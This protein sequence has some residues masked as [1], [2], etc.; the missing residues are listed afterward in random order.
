MIVKL[1]AVSATLI[2]GTQT[3]NFGIML[4]LKPLNVLKN[5]SLSKIQTDYHNSTSIHM[6]HASS[7]VLHGAGYIIQQSRRA[8]HRA[9]TIT[10][11]RYPNS[12]PK[13]VAGLVYLQ[14]TMLHNY[15]IVVPKLMR[16]LK[17]CFGIKRYTHPSGFYLHSF[18]FG[19]QPY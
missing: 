15:H 3:T 6:L 2:I 9:S 11:R 8:M 1:V 17:K 7:A 14:A 18:V 5:A 19:Y 12:V 4:G 13:T 10:S 16:K